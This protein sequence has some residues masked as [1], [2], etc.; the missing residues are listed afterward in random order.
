[1]T[2]RTIANDAENERNVKIVLDSFAAVEQ[3]DE[4]RQAELFHP[5]A[6]FLWPPSLPYSRA[7][8]LRQ[9]GFEEAWDPFQ[10]TDAERCLDPRVVAAE[11]NEVVVLWQQRGVDGAG[12]RFECPVLGLYEVRD[13]K[14]VRGQMF[15]FDS[16]ATTSFLANAN[17]LSG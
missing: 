6:E 9:L 15:Y 16:A 3:R 12:N 8:G 17:G 14:L 2:N 13:G 5:E 7:Q 10:P 11:G 4:R 1:M